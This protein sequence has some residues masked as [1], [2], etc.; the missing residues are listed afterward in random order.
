MLLYISWKLNSFLAATQSSKPIG[1]LVSRNIVNSHLLLN[2]SMVV[3]HRAMSSEVHFV[4][5]LLMDASSTRRIQ[6]L[7]P[8]KR[9]LFKAQGWRHLL[10]VVSLMIVMT[11]AR[12][13]TR[14]ILTTI[15]QR[16]GYHV[17][18]AYIDLL[19]CPAS[20]TFRDNNSWPFFL[21]ARRFLR[22]TKF[23]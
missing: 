20:T 13:D 1:Q 18:N 15:R 14:H 19:C 23:C 22:A 9:G 12:V 3:A 21:R 7:I 4:G 8:G 17:Q 11:T 6:G 5:K 10:R 2:L 16:P